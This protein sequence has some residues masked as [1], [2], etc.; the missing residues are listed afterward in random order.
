[1]RSGP[2]AIHYQ[3]TL[4]RVSELAWVKV[5]PL[6]IWRRI[7]KYALMG[8][9]LVFF[10]AVW[11]AKGTFW[12]IEGILGFLSF[13]IGYSLRGDTRLATSGDLV[14]SYD[15][16]G[17]E[18]ERSTFQQ[19]VQAL[20]EGPNE[21]KLGRPDSRYYCWVNLE[22]V[23]WARKN[24]AFDFYGLTALPIYL[25]YQ[26]LI[27]KNLSFTISPILEDLKLLRFLNGD[28]HSVSLC[29]YAI[30][31]AGLVAAVTSVTPVIEVRACGGLSD[32]F[33][34][35]S[36]DQKR[37]FDKLAGLAPAE[38]AEPPQKPQPKPEPIANAPETPPSPA[39]TAS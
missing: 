23:A 7:V 11:Q 12:N 25:G 15:A 22:R 36:A 24:F 3:G 5:C 18:G 16:R 20:A 8:L 6:P 34:V 39:E 30:A 33:A 26:W 14:E 17:T 9:G 28:I 32:V 35:S 38:T 13:H 10:Y 27:A 4:F 1:M 19:W 2:K 31:A 37:F 21:C 29:C